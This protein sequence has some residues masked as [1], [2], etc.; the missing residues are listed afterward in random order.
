MY[1]FVVL[2]RSRNV[3]YVNRSPRESMVRN[4]AAQSMTRVRAPGFLSRAYPLLVR[5]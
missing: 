4:S 5:P 2:K 1:V 3:R